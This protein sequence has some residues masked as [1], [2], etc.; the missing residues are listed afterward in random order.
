MKLV[1]QVPKLLTLWVRLALNQC[2]LSLLTPNQALQR[3][4]DGLLI[5]E[6]G[7]EG[8]VLVNPIGEIV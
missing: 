3:L 6:V 1:L 8:M 7:C 2:K 5:S 4:K